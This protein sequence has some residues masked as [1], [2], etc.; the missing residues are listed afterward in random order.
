MTYS[1]FTLEQVRTAFALHLRQAALFPQVAAVAVPD[2]LPATLER[3]RPF[4]LTSEKARSELI[5]VPILL[6]SM[7]RSAAPRSLYSGQRLD[8]APEHGLNGECDFLLSNQPA[9]P[10]LQAP[11]L[12]IVQAKENDIEGELGQCAAQMV[13]ARRFNEREGSDIRTI[14]GC[15]TSGESWQFLRLEADTL[16]LDTERYYRVNLGLLL[17]VFA[18]IDAYY[19]PA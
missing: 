10:I 19:L 13:G 17:G 9:L 18:A 11:M 4:A 6:A 12:T 7:E 3:G 5:V 1:D 14:F 16:V 15:V 2:W 8:V